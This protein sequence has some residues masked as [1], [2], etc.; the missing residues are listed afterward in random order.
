MVEFLMLKS[1]DQSDMDRESVA[2][3]IQTL[4]E[5]SM[6]ESEQFMEVKYYSHLHSFGCLQ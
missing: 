6:V 2:K 3:L 1:L 5:E 4:K